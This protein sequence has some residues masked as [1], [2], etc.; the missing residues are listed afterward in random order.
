M[1]QRCYV[2]QVIS[3]HQVYDQCSVNFYQAE[4]KS[5]STRMLVGVD[6]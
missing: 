3:W 5:V 4:L 6:N 1:C 2:N